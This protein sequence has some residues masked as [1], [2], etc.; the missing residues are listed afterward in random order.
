MRKL[1]NLF[2]ASARLL[3]ISAPISL[4][5]ASLAGC[6]SNS[7]DDRYNAMSAEQIY[8]QGTK[9]IDKKRY[10][11]AVEDFEALESRYPFGEYADKAQF[12]ALYA[13]YENEDY[14]AALPAIE[15]FLRMYPRHPHVDYAYYMKGLVHFSESLGLFGKYLPTERAERDPTSAKK[16]LQA[17][18]ILTTHYPH[19]IY[20][21]DAKL[22]M[23]YLRNLLAKHEL[24]AARF[25]MKKGAYLS[26]A[27]RANTVITEFDR[28]A[29]MPEA[30][31]IMIKAYRQLELY[32]L[33]DDAY[34]VLV[35]NYPQ[36][37]L[38][39]QLA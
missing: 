18:E 36:S 9:H 21:N 35:L 38:V 2:S 10:T 31:G 7:K 4:L 30:L 8:A 3:C 32:T 29:S 20:L 16:A 34:A 11:E 25:Y 6:N 12:G 28:T 26:A 22:R 17:F 39:D 37:P 1:A 23:V 13:L 24:A 15:R 5:I 27:N 19:S 33:A 14:P